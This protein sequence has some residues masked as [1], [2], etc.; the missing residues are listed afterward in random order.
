[1]SIALPLPGRDYLQD[2]GPRH[3]AGQGPA[4]LCQENGQNVAK[5]EYEES[6]RQG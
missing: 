1:M 2:Q 5:E 3:P 6:R 4:K